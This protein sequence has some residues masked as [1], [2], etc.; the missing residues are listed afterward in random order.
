MTTAPER[1]WLLV[2]TIGIMICSCATV[3]IPP[4]ESTVSALRAYYDELQMKVTSKELT[5]TEAR[6]LYYAKLEQIR[7]PLPDLEALLEFRRQVEATAG[8]AEESEARLKAR[9]SELLRKWEELA[10][11]YAQEQRR[12]ER[13]QREYERGLKDEQTPVSGRPF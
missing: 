10:A 1:R 13:L 12:Q 6:N 9:E 5:R 4:S 11:Q 7:P 2:V 3:A 8:S